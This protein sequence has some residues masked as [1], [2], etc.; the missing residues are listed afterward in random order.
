MIPYDYTR[1]FSTQYLSYFK[2][3]VSQRPL[4]SQDT[5]NHA[6]LILLA[7][8]ACIG[9]VWSHPYRVGAV[10]QQPLS[11]LPKV[12]GLYLRLIWMPWRHYWHLVIPWIRTVANSPVPLFPSFRRLGPTSHSLQSTLPLAGLLGMD[13]LGNATTVSRWDVCRDLP[14]AHLCAPCPGDRWLACPDGNWFGI[15]PHYFGADAPYRSTH[16]LWLSPVLY[17]TM[18]PVCTLFTRELANC[19]RHWKS[20]HIRDVITFVKHVWWL[21]SV[22]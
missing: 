3:H 6:T 5:L 17:A 13:S 4:N 20:D 8:R 11:L 16:H 7:L 14:V 1:Y 9:L 18:R 22:A 15:I 12:L 2:S 10:N 21:F 19:H